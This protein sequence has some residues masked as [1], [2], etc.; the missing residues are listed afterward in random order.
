MD[1]DYAP[2][3]KFQRGAEEASQINRVPIYLVIACQVLLDTANVLGK[4]CSDGFTTVCN[5][6][7]VFQD[8]LVSQYKLRK[9]T[10]QE[11]GPKHLSHVMP[12]LMK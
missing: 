12:D 8:T 5:I 3:D 6:C 1:D 9:D 11:P 4:K 7:V 2:I 10:L